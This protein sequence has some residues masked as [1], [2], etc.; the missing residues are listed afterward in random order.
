MSSNNYTTYGAKSPAWGGYPRCHTT[1]KPMVVKDSQGVELVIHGGSC[2]VTPPEGMDVLIA[3]DRGYVLVP[4]AMPWLDGEFVFF[5]ITDMD[6]PKS[7]TQ[8]KNL[9]KWTAEQLYA[10]KKVHAG[11]IGG[12]GRTGLFLSALVMYLSGEKDATTWV[13]AN[14]CHKAVESSKQVEW[15]HKNFGIE[16]AKPT[17]GY[18]LSAGSAGM[19]HSKQKAVGKGAEALTPMQ[20]KYCIHG[21]KSAGNIVG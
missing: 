11:C 7:L 17:K 20:A 21:S 14:Y 8:F 19:P 6:V 2:T 13:R 16:K 10:G 3:F 15:L 5:P 4:H 12:H 9:I 1:H 18:G